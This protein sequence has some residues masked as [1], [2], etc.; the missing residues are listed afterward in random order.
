MKKGEEFTNIVNKGA[1]S[2]LKDRV[3]GMF[4]SD[5]ET[6]SKKDKKIIEKERIR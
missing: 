1:L 4:K 3:V 5:Q 2:Y 6:L